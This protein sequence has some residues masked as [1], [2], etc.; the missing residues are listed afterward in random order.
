MTLDLVK[1]IM[2]FEFYHTTQKANPQKKKK[3]NIRDFI[4]DFYSERPYS[5]IQKA[6]HKLW[7]NYLQ[8]T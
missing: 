1:Q 5:E 7:E 8:N 4:K 3:I 6:S 2:I